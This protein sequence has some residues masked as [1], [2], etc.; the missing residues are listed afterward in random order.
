MD[1]VHNL[2]K[3]QLKRFNLNLDDLSD[4]IKEFVSAVNEAYHQ[5][6]EDRKLLERSLDLSS[7]E[8]LQANSELR[9]IFKSFPDM[10]FRMNY[11]G[12]ILDFKVGLQDEM[13]PPLINLVGTKISDMPVTAIRKGLEGSIIEIRQN[14]E[15]VSLQFSM[16]GKTNQ[17]HF[18]ARLLPLLENQIICIIRNITEAK[19][20]ELELIRNE[21][22]VRSVLESSPDPIVVYTMGGVA[23]YANPA[24]SKIFGWDLEALQDKDVKFVPEE[25]RDETIEKIRLLK[26]GKNVMGFETKRF[27]KQGNVLDVIINA[28]LI[29]DSESR[30]TGSVVTI[31][32]ISERK[33]LEAELLY[34]MNQA[35]SANQ[36]KTEFLTNMSHE[37]RTP[38][39][40]ILGF[41]QLILENYD[42]YDSKTVL[43]FLNEVY[44]AGQRLMIL[45]DDLLDLSKLEVGRVDYEFKPH[46]LSEIIQLVMKENISLA[47][48]KEIE[49]VFDIT[50]ETNDTV[51][52]DYNRMI[53]VMRNLLSNAIKF[54][55]EKSKIE[56]KVVRQSGIVIATFKDFGIGIPTDELETVFDKFV[57][58]SKTKTG[59]G[60]TGLGLA[61]CHEIIKAHQ[62]R[63]WANNNAEGGATFNVSLAAI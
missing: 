33:K 16:D 44:D 25:F 47:A 50:P 7:Q 29:F 17:H 31:V 43:N 54:S 42:Q 2:L 21:R 45:L 13:Y 15:M 30:P 3:R 19:N 23:E 52:I 62:G 32:D 53:Q 40:A 18:E 10:F 48:E 9:A 26:E 63:I 37:L 35:N 4:D 39:H 56:I 34:A 1:K 12:E 55:F 46:R 61:I 20:A 11:E 22:Q 36:A 14:S 41:A 60:G 6:D 51:D 8:L 59:A 38:M 24:F 27:D 58:S 5:S 28:S 49:L 57:Q